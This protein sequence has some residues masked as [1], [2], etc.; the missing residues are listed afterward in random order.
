MNISQPGQTPNPTGELDRIL[1]HEGPL[2]P[3]SGFAAS[4]MDAIQTQ[5]AQP[6]PIPFPWM[7]ALPGIAAL[8]AVVIA[9]VIAVMVFLVR[10]AAT[11]LRSAPTIQVDVLMPQLAAVPALPALAALVA[12]LACCLLCLRLTLGRSAP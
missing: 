8:I 7:R 5:G 1:A 4:V 11:A 2:L 10:F 3:S 12:S 9:V 6:A